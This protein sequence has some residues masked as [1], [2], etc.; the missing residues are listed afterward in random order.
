MLGSP[1]GGD[2]A[3]ELVEE[4][5]GV[6][7]AGGGFRVKTA[8]K[9]R[10]PD[11]GAALVAAVVEVYK[12]RLDIGGQGALIDGVAVILAGDERTARAD[13]AAP[14]DCASDGQTA[15]CTSRPPR[16]RARS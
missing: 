15:A 9:Q 14:A 10:A 16:Q 4:W 11:G 12:P 3:Q 1:A 8:R 5:R 7:W 6:A 2:G 13:P